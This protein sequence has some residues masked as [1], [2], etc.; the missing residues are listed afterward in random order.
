MK[1]L[2][3]AH[4]FAP[5]VGGAETLVSLLARGAAG[6]MEVTV[7]AATP[8]GPEADRGLPF[9]LVRRPGLI[10][11]WR[12]IRDADVVH[13]AGPLMAPL[14]MARLLGRPVVI[15]HHGYQAAC[16]NGLLFHQ[17]SDRACS[18]AFLEA[19]YLT[20]A[21]CR[22]ASVGWLAGLLSV[23]LTFPRRSLSRRAA[24]NIA[25]T[26]HVADRLRLPVTTVIQHGVPASPPDVRTADE[27]GALTFGYVGRLVREKGLAVLLDA[28]AA[29]VREGRRFNLV[30][31]G[32]GPERES[33]E[34]QAAR[35]GVPAEFAGTLGADPLEAA[36]RRMDVV[37]MPSIWEETAGLAAMEAMRR[38]A[39]VIASQCG[40]LPEIVGEAGMLVPTGDA[41]ALADAMRRLLDD[42]GLVAKLGA[43]ARNRAASRFAVDRMVD[44]HLEAWTRAAAR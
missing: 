44:E 31:V 42:R 5:N 10:A 17:P 35:Q 26:R 12:L 21:R 27:S 37:I 39:A 6:R 4:S 16:P 30:V 11:L 29:L 28:A 32:G 34:A 15:E 36:A 40:G 7:A 1:L 24:V 8:A 2:I 19:R 23:G 3:C 43:L 9:N 33:L 14:V 25:V 20:C 13:L 38:G 18:G 22:A 41:H